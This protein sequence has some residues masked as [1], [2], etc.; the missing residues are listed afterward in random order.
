MTGAAV[1]ASQAVSFACYGGP[2]TI[3]VSGL[4][5]TFR[6]IDVSHRRMTVMMMPGMIGIPGMG[7]GRCHA[8]LT[9]RHCHRCVALQRQPQRD[10]Y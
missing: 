3:D 1:V 10:Q 6:M 4:G 7:R 5:N 2:R 8:V 9:E